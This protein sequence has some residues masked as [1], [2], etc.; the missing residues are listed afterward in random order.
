MLEVLGAAP[1][2]SP[3][4]DDGY[5]RFNLEGRAGL[6][7]RLRGRGKPI[8]MALAASVAIL[9]DATTPLFRIMLGFDFITEDPL[10]DSD[11]DGVVNSRDRCLTEAED[12]D[13][14]RDNDGCPEWDNDSDG[15]VDADDE[16]P[17]DAEDKDGIDDDDGCPDPDIPDSDKDGL[18]DKEDQCP[19]EPED[20]DGFEDF[21][22]CPD[23]DNDNDGLKDLNDLC[24]DAAEDR[25]GFEDDDG[26]PDGGKGRRLLSRDGNLIRLH[27]PLRFRPKSAELEPRSLDVLDQ[28]SALLRSDTDIARLRLLVYPEGR[29]R[30]RRDQA[31]QRGRNVRN[32]LRKRF[33]ESHRLRAEVADWD[34]RLAGSVVLQIVK[35]SRA[36]KPPKAVKKNKSKK[37]RSRRKR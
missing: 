30:K 10:A 22:G 21:D 29:S 8:S 1:I 24:P 33:I 17:L 32:E 6:R 36:V 9:D 2:P 7:Q 37:K 3:N 27:Q 11:D 26:C 31:A 16:C 15:V 34:K 18:Y 20:A 28:L 4:G 14:Y 19:M 35:I 25:N 12:Q 5:K 13:G 23:L